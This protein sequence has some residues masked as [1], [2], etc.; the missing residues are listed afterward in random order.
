MFSITYNGLIVS[1]NEMKNNH[2][3][4]FK[5]KADKVK[6]ES[7]K[8]IQAAKLPIFSQ[9]EITAFFNGRQD[10]D[11]IMAT[12]KFWIDSLVK[13]GHLKND[14]KKYYPESSQKFASHLPKGTIIFQ[15]K[16]LRGR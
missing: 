7:E 1:M 14:T 5:P 13:L 15:I 6:N 9:V 10:L 4:K 11:N 16:E 8:V 12:Q 3:T 2:W